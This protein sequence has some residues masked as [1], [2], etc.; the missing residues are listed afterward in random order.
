MKTI[1]Y[2]LILTAAVGCSPSLFAQIIMPASG[3]GSD[4][5]V[6]TVRPTVRNV[7]SAESG[8]WKPSSSGWWFQNRASSAL[9][10]G[11]KYRAKDTRAMVDKNDR[12]NVDYSIDRLSYTGGFRS[13]ALSGDVSPRV[14]TLGR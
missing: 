11:F 9:D 5:G 2:S 10:L 13:P 14:S 1:L 12:Y 8:G 6:N 7:I 3:T 4:L